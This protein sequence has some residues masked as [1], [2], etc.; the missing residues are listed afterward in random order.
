M[1]YFLVGYNILEQDVKRALSMKSGV[2]KYKYEYFR[3]DSVKVLDSKDFSVY[4]LSL[5]EINQEEYAIT[6]THIPVYNELSVNILGGMMTKNK[7]IDRVYWEEKVNSPLYYSEKLVFPTS[8]LIHKFIEYKNFEI[9]LKINLI[10]FDVYLEAYGF[11]VLGSDTGEF[12]GVGLAGRNKM[13]H[14]LDTYFSSLIEKYDSIDYVGDTLAVCDLDYNKKDYIL[15]NGIK[16]VIVIMPISGEFNLVLPP[17][18]EHISILNM[19]NI[20]NLY[21]AIPKAKF[22]NIVNDLALGFDDLKDSEKLD[23][24]A[25]YKIT[26]N[27]Y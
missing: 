10:T 5:D 21:I 15:K 17:T 19:F 2:N 8:N 25:D 22:N 12:E 1:S 16:N 14:S 20:N 27:V 7:V 6:G 9:K 18:I 11:P 26:L 24:I 4:D 3:F 23:A 13:S